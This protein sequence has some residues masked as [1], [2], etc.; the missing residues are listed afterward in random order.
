M[1]AAV[2]AIHRM[3]LTAATIVGFT[4]F[5]KV[6]ADAMQADVGG[7]A[8][9]ALYCALFHIISC[10]SYL[11]IHA[12]K[13]RGE[14]SGDGVGWKY[15]AL[16][17]LLGYTSYMLVLWAY[18]LAPKVSYLFAFRQF[19]IVIGVVLAFRLYR[20]RGLAVRLPATAAIV[21]GLVLLKLWG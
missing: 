13:D 2:S 12:V 18:Q 3:S 7:P 11:I 19:S 9:A 1:V 8:S 17:G 16:G 15:P 20:E 4:R 21:V 10:V 5:D 14:Q 6:G